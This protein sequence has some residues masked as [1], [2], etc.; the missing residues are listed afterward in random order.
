[1]GRWETFPVGLSQQ[2]DEAGGS[3]IPEVRVRVGSSPDNDGTG[4]HRQTARARQVRR[5]GVRVQEPV[6]E[7]PKVER[8]LEPDGSGPVSGAHRSKVAAVTSGQSW[9]GRL[10][11]HDEVLRGSCGEAAGEE[12]DAD[13]VERSVVNVGTST[14]PPVITVSQTGRGQAHARLSGV[15]WGGAA[16]VV[17]DRE[18]RSHGQGRQRV[19]S[20]RTGK[21]GGRR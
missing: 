12:L 3:L 2:P 13:P 8:R 16:V 4:R 14:R 20:G 19:R 21:S 18:S 9:V 7:P 1:V 5:R 11:G 10:G 17:R 6:V 15:C